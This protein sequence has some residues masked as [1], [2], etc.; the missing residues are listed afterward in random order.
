MVHFGGDGLV[1]VYNVFRSPR[2]SSK[3]DGALR[4]PAP[5]LEVMQH[6]GAVDARP[7]PDS[8]QR[9]FFW[10]ACIHYALVRDTNYDQ[11]AAHA[12]DVAATVEPNTHAEGAAPQ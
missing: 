7:T 1:V 12:F 6:Q 4:T 8:K 2:R 3:G 11:N 10:D 9:T 5:V